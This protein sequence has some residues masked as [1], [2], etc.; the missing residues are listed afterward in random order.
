M[1]RRNEWKVRCWALL[2]AG[3]LGISN[4]LL[5]A[6][7]SVVRVSESE[8]KRLVVSRVEPQY[9]PMARQM[10]VTGRV[11]VDAY[12]EPDGSVEKVQVVNGN[13]ILGNAAV[14][15]VKQWK[16]IPYKAGGTPARAVAGFAFDF[17]M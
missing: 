10:K 3:G 13:P 17:K 1:F 2:L 9:P 8:A 11:Q 15:A 7:D 14:A 4:A 6:Q 12:I 5:R 16:F